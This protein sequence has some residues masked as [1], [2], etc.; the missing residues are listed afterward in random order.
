MELKPLIP[1]RRHLFELGFLFLVSLV[2]LNPLEISFSLASIDLS[3]ESI[4]NAVLGLGMLA[5][6]GMI[7]LDWLQVVIAPMPP[8]TMVASG[9]TFG[10]L[11]G[12]LYSFI[13]MSLGSLTAILLGRKFGQ[14]VVEKVVSEE[15][16]EKFH[17]LTQRH[18][19]IVFTVIFLFP[20]FPD[21][22]VCYLAGLTDLDLKKLYL[23]AS[24]GRIPTV[25]TLT[26]TGNSIA[27]ANIK[28]M[29][30]A[31]GVF[32]G[33]SYVSVRNEERII[34]RAS[35]LEKSLEGFIPGF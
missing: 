31:L 18:G 2:L 26:L 8:V 4:K 16:M 6:V 28:L 33:L 10:F 27:V 5:P 21:D 17:D 15:H 35:N 25:L 32:G 22:V 24:L 19:L 1:S 20:G 23:S 3:P 9:Y 30:G 13:G 14:K 29:V 12:S 34:Q 11:F 7:F